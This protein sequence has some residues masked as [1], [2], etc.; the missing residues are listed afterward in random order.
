MADDD[1]ETAAEI[2]AADAEAA[3]LVPER[4]RALAIFGSQVKVDELLARVVETAKMRIPPDANMKV[5]KDRDAVRGAARFVASSKRALDKAGLNLTA[6]MRAA[7]A[8]VNRERGRIVDVLTEQQAEIRAPLTAHERRLAA[9]NERL[10]S[11]F[12]PPWSDDPEAEFGTVEIGGEI[13]RVQNVAIDDHWQEVKA[14]AAVRK[15]EALSK[16]R[17]LY[18]VAE[19]RE[20]EAAELERLRAAEVER[21]RLEALAAEQKRRDEEAAEG[22]R[23]A[24]EAEAKRKKAEA[25]RQAQI[26]RDKAA[27]A[28]RARKEA[29]QAAAVKIEAA[30]KATADAERRLEEAAAKA[31]ADAAAAKVKAEQETAAAVEAERQRLAAERKRQAELDAKAAANKARRERNRQ[32][33][34][35]AVERVL[36]VTDD[37]PD[38]KYRRSPAERITDAL[39]KPGVIPCM[40]YEP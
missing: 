31:E 39:M 15:D 2:E 29:E 16:L 30:R 7:I 4:G 17:K 21:Q 33:I 36:A 25:E 37:V 20:A 23:L 22:K 10:R 11:V 6:D 3:S 13:R 35:A 26:D 5:A 40:R 18:N 28:E 38:P 32:A 12:L 19:K 1:V 14:E 34:L 24:E 9:L 27:A 8:K